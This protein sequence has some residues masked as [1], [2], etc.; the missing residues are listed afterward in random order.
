[1]NGKN[2]LTLKEMLEKYHQANPAHDGFLDFANV[3]APHLGSSGKDNGTNGQSSV[4]TE[5]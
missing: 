2:M 5:K 3:I 4:N 1:M